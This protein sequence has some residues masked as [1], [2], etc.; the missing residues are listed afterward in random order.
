MIYKNITRQ[1]LE[2]YMS[3]TLVWLENFDKTLESTEIVIRDTDHVYNSLRIEFSNYS[4]L[5]KVHEIEKIIDRYINTHCCLC[6]ST[7]GV[8]LV[9]YDDKASSEI[10]NIFC[11]NCAAELEFKNQGLYG[12]LKF[13]IENDCSFRLNPKLRIKYKSGEISYCRLQDINYKEGNLFLDNGNPKKGW[14]NRTLGLLDKDDI[15]IVGADTGLRDINDER[16]YDGDIIICTTKDRKRFGGMLLTGPSGWSNRNVGPNPKWGTYRV[17]HGVGNLPSSLAWAQN[18][19]IIGG[20]GDLSNFNGFGPDE[21]WFEE[22]IR[23]N[24]EQFS[25]Y[26]E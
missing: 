18:F 4:N 19:Q 3:A 2:P 1:E 22:W 15:Y 12:Y 11:K 16:A 8:R 5:D 24:N 21:R 26:F 23:I 7:Y 10:L 25:Q 9:P 13:C 17:C 6:G 14:F 20:V